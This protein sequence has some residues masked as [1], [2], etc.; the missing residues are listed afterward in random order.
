MLFTLS[1]IEDCKGLGCFP[2]P[3]Q[4]VANLVLS[5][6]SKASQWVYVNYDVIVVIMFLIN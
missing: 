6:D 3:D 1:A 5:L 4:E 2:A